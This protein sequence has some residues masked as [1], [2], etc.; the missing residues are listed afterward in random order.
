MR[1]RPFTFVSITVRSSSSEES[2]NGS[3]PSASPAALTRMSSPSSSFTR[4]GDEG[5]AAVRVGHVERQPDRA[6]AD[7]VEP[8]DPPGTGGDVDALR[9]TSARAVARPIPLEAPVTI[10]V[11]PSSE[12]TAG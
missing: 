8:L 4:A 11:L 3:R 1:I 12:G 5:C 7:L 6:L 10:A 9:A 2:S